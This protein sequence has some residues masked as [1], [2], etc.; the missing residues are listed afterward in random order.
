MKERKITCIMCPKGCN[1]SV[2]FAEDGSAADISGNSCPRGHE[3]A[4]NEVHHPVRTLTS[5]VRTASGRMVAVKSSVPVP[6]ELLFDVMACI[7]TV[8][9]EEPVKFG[10]IVI[11]N[12]CGTD[13]DIVVTSE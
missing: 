8:R 7:N 13:A 3:Y 11:N 5:T 4:W 12:V 6:K 10:D 1:I 2:T 9:P